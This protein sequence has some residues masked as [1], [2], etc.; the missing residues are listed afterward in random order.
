[1]LFSSAPAETKRQKDLVA[2]PGADGDALA[3]RRPAT[4]EH[5]CSRF[6]LHPRA[7]AVR[8][9]AMPPVGLKCA[10]GHEMRSCFLSEILAST[11]SIKYIECLALNPVRLQVSGESLVM[12]H[13]VPTTVREAVDMRSQNEETHANS[14]VM[15]GI[16][17]SGS[18]RAICVSEFRLQREKSR[19][20]VTCF[21]MLGA[22]L[23]ALPKLM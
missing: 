9:R 6:G 20:S 21:T 2:I 13:F 11:A 1:M 17:D 3:A 14:R 18:F 12:T 15:I 10:L 22:S 5:G 4:A 23:N 7:K 19:S 8:L 16:Q